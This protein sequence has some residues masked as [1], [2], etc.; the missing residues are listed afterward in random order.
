MKNSDQ[1]GF[2]LLELM[3]AVGLFTVAIFMIMVILFAITNAQRKVV[4]IQ[5]S[6]DNLRFA[7]EAMIKEIR[8]GREF[9]CGATGV[10][11]L[12]QNCTFASSGDTSFTFLN[13]AGQRVTYRL[14]Y[15]NNA[16]A[17]QLV[18]SSNG[19]LPCD[20]D[21]GDVI[22]CQRITATQ[23]NV[24][25]LRFYV[26]GT[27]GGDDKQSIATIVLEGDVPDAKVGTTKISLQ[28]TVS[29]RGFVDQP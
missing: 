1:K 22:D 15:N 23:V 17:Y 26:D 20:G 21:T 12:P 29:K 28:A 16:D 3:V 18:K 7:F 13:S 14:Y 19:T 2:T 11:S 24:S 27:A 4:N 8:T 25:R 5:N 10:L 9:H 6:Q